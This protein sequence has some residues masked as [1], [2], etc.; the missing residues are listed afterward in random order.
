MVSLLENAKEEPK[1]KRLRYAVTGVA[2]VLLLGFWTWHTMRFRGEEHTIDHLMDAVTSGNFQMA[3]QIWKPH[4][5]GSYTFDGF[6]SRLGPE[7]LLRAGEKLSARIVVGASQWRQRRN[8]HRG[9]QPVRS[10][11]HE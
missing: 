5:G 7:G 3:Y 9:D 11:S 10:V 6:C 1:S 8:R 2:L 4:Q